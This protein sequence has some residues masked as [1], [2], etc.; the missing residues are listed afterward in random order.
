MLI[1]GLAASVMKSRSQ[2]PKPAGH[3]GHE[4]TVDL[5]ELGPITDVTFR[6]D[7]KAEGWTHQTAIQI[8]DNTAHG[9]GGPTL[10]IRL[11]LPSP[12]H[13]DEQCKSAR[14]TARD[15]QQTRPEL[16]RQRLRV[17]EPR[18]RGSR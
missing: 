5:T 14:E 15:R 4:L 10:V 11:N 8:T 12:L 6:P 16:N 9:S 3:S 2:A 13:T 18:H 1:A 17:A 7:G